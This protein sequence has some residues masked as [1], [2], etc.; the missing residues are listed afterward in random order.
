MNN[1]RFIAPVLIFGLIFLMSLEIAVSG[2]VKEVRVTA[3]KAP[4]QDEVDQTF[5]SLVNNNSNSISAVNKNLLDLTNAAVIA[6]D[7]ND[8]DTVK[9]RLAQLQSVLINNSEGS[10]LND[11]SSSSHSKEVYVSIGPW[12]IDSESAT[13]YSPNPIEIS[14]DQTV[15]WTNDDSAFHTVT[16]GTVGSA[17]TGKAFDSGLAD[18]TALTSK[19]KNI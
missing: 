18:P 19:G 9:Q 6:L 4:D 8:I 16:S 10:M 2:D 11:S 17:D 5:L 7:N 13:A 1:F 14:V 15:I 12:S 3:F